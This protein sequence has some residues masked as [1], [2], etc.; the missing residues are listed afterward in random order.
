M[1]MTRRRERRRAPRLKWQT[2][3]QLATEEKEAEKERKRG[4]SKAEFTELARSSF[5][6][7]CNIIMLVSRFLSSVSP[8]TLYCSSGGRPCAGRGDRPCAGLERQTDHLAEKDLKDGH[9]RWRTKGAPLPAAAL[10]QEL[11]GRW[12]QWHGR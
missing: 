8:L 1:C 2:S 5:A 3:S 6:V 4:R 11:L 7:S 12:P 9:S 10:E